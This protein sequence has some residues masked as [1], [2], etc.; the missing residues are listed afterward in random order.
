MKRKEKEKPID[1]SKGLLD[2]WSDKVTELNL[3]YVHINLN[4][5]NPDSDI[6]NS[7]GSFAG[8][9]RE[10]GKKK[11][12]EKSIVSS[13][14]LK[15]DKDIPRG[16]SEKLFCSKGL[17]IVSKLN[18]P[19]KRETD[20]SIC[21]DYGA[22]FPQNT[23][24]I[25][26]D[27]RITLKKN[28]E[29][30]SNKKTKEISPL[31]KKAEEVREREL[32]AKNNWNDFIGELIVQIEKD[33]NDVIKV[34]E[35][36]NPKI[37]AEEFVTRNGLKEKYVEKIRREISSKIFEHFNEKQEKHILF[38]LE[39]DLGKKGKDTI[40]FYMGDDPK[41]LAKKFIKKNDLPKAKY[42]RVLFLIQE[43]FNATLPS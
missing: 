41:T 11:P 21:Y 33:R 18:R 8:S 22:N 1:E 24:E 12:N 6:S 34:K 7:S 16:I 27:I 38:K 14:S 13:V 32:S 15:I 2:E 39:V 40:I 19:K 9:T 31:L 5:E 23:S 3:E 17:E 29:K 42:K 37:L 25:C 20:E 36:D 30:K 28:Q 35:S 26:V 4:A 10:E 43:S